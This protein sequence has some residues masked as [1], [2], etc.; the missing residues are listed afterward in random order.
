MLHHRPEIDVGSY[1][2]NGKKLLNSFLPEGTRQ[3]F[4]IEMGD[5]IFVRKR[6]KIGILYY[7]NLNLVKYLKNFDEIW[8]T[9]S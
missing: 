6:Q 8:I 4:E 2:Q 5:N 9:E 3:N 1:W 7:K